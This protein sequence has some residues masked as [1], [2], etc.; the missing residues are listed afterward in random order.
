[1][2]ILKL[3]LVLVGL[4]F[5]LP[6]F[7]QT[8]TPPFRKDSIAG[9]HAPIDTIKKTASDTIRRT[10]NDTTKGRTSVGLNNKQGKNGGQTVVKDSARLALEALPRKAALSSAI[11][12]GWGQVRNGRWWKVPFVYGGLVSVALALNFNQHYYSKYVKE[13]RYHYYNG[14]FMDPELN[15]RNID[16]ASVQSAVDYY[17]RNRD[18]SILGLL[19]VHAINIIDA[20]IDAKFFRYDISDKLAFKLEPALM[21]PLSYANVL[22]VPAIKLSISL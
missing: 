13:L 9:V 1:M 7:S 16:T 8:E 20:Y 12:P 4:A 15:S 18:L 10:A 22:P 3:Y 6:V 19:G 21:P 17:R 2:R 5:S 14:T 11:I